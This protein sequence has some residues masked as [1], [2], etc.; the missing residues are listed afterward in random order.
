MIETKE[1]K[2]KSAAPKKQ[3]AEIG[4]VRKWIDL[5]QIAKNPIPIIARNLREHGGIY[6]VSTIVNPNIIMTDRVEVIEHVLQRN[7]RNYHKSKLQTEGLGKYLGKG[8]LTLNGAPW[9][10]QRR[11][12]Q[13][14][15]H[16]KK[17]EELSHTMMNV[18]DQEHRILDQ[19]ASSGKTF[20]M[21]KF[22]MELTYKVVVR[23]LFGTAT[24]ETSLKRMGH[25]IDFLQELIINKNRKPYMRPWFWLNRTEHKG[26]Q[27]KAEVDEF[28][29]QVIDER[30][31]S[32]KDSSDLLDMLLK[33]RYEDTGEPMSSAQIRDEALVLIAAGHETSANA[34]TWLFRL[35]IKHPNVV[36]KIREE[37]Q[38]VCPDGQVHFEHLPQLSYT[39]Q[40]IEE[41]MRL[42][43][44]AWA[45]DRVA[46][47]DDEVNGFPIPKGSLIISFIYGLHRR[48]DLWADPQAF[49]PERFHKD[50]AKSRKRFQYIP[51]GGGPRLC[52]GNSFA[53]MEMQMIVATLLRRFDFSMIKD[54]KIE[55]L[56]LI[57]LRPKYGIKMK[58]HL[59]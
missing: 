42:H 12:I 53:M 46:L 26:D 41:G 1:R 5:P 27:M 34:M 51:F 43:P 18:I 13:P 31:S 23:G 8:L 39:K 25:I 29:M 35:F 22:M 6:K 54:Q 4:N 2:S 24:D 15:F 48:A 16:K 49:I 56:P 45:V 50:N 52:I 44:P 36:Q 17:L 40:C 47:E 59:R 32:G 38:R 21:S 37:V 10:K 58:A 30:R 11:L 7:N 28:L 14:G 19:Y 57:T 9:L 33:S 55:A 3:I 20:D